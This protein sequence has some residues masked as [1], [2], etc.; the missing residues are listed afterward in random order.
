MALSSLDSRLL[1]L[2]GSLPHCGKGQH[3]THWR[4]AS[5]AKCRQKEFKGVFGK[6]RFYEGQTVPRKFQTFRPLYRALAEP[7]YVISKQG[8][9]LRGSV[10]DQKLPNLLLSKFLPL[11]TQWKTVDRAKRGRESEKGNRAFSDLGAYFWKN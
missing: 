8:L 4:E 10:N 6:D 7:Y 5:E 1:K 11:N 3:Q 2:P 9:C